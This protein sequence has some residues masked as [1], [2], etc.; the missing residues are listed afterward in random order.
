MQGN[1]KAEI[2]IFIRGVVLSTLYICRLS[3]PP[4]YVYIS[5]FISRQAPNPQT[6][7]FVACLCV[8]LQLVLEVGISDAL[9]IT[10]NLHE[11][12]SWLIRK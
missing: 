4:M 12:I 3:T 11:E 8:S 2:I 9:R 1:C 7:L 6:T 5:C 10:P